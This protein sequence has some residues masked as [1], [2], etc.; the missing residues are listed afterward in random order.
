MIA[1]A[2]L[3]TRMQEQIESMTRSLLSEKAEVGAVR[4]S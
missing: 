2:S 3:H 1:H 4:K